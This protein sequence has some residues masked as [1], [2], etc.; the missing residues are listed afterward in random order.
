MFQERGR[1]DLIKQF[2]QD[3][4]RLVNPIVESLK[5]EEYGLSRETI[6]FL[7]SPNKVR[8]AGN[9]RAHNATRVEIEN[10][11][12]MHNSDVTGTDRCL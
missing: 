12:I 6:Q 3:G 11:I 10:A 7:F 9:D 4:V 8:R 2:H 1:E 5:G